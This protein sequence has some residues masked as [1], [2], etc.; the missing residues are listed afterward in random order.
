MKHFI[1][2]INYLV[3]VDQL[4][5]VLPNHRAFLQTGYDRGLLLLSGPRE[6][7]IGGMVVARANSLEEIQEFFN[8]DPYH[9]QKVATHTF[10]E[11]NPVLHQ[12]WLDNWVKG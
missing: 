8:N 9:L 5:D 12:P 11:F 2:E 10:I 1:V 6:P 3:P 4:S 7:R